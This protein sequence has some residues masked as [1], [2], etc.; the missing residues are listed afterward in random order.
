[1]ANATR[2]SAAVSTPSTR[3]AMRQLKW[4]MMA[5]TSRLLST[6]AAEVAVMNRPMAR[7]RSRRGNQV[8][9]SLTPAA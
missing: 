8:A 3:Y 5:G 6:T 2:P 9:I 4:S 7:P 1:M